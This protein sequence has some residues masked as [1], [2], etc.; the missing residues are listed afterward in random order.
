M[1]VLQEEVDQFIPFF[2]LIL[3]KSCCGSFTKELHQA[4]LHHD[5]EHPGK[6]EE[7]C[8]EDQVERNPLI[9]RVVDYCGGVHVLVS[10]RTGSFVLSW[11][12]PVLTKKTLKTLPGVKRGCCNF[13]YQVEYIQQY[14]SSTSFSI[15]SFA[16]PASH[17]IG[18]PKNC[19]VKIFQFIFL[20]TR[21]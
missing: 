4:A 3:D 12:V 14:D 10:A 18:E 8:Q 1:D 11:N 6:I 17:W 21:S 9:I 13:P 5:P 19:L 16:D 15:P 20:L 7:E 2:L